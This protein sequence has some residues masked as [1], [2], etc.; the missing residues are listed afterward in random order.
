MDLI[1]FWPYTHIFRGEESKAVAD[2]PNLSLPSNQKQREI[3]TGT[4]DVTPNDLTYT[5][6]IGVQQRI[7]AKSNEQA[8][9]DNGSENTVL[10]A[11]G[12]TRT[13]NLS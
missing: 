5:G 12:R 10:N 4:D 9:R 13:C 1:N 2:L 6:Q 7:S 8:N 11:P 3:A